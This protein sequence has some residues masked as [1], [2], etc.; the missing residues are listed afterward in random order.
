[1]TATDEFLQRIAA[2]LDNAFNGSRR[3]KPTGFVLLTFPFNGAPGNRVNYIS[4][5]NRADVVA[6]LE[7]IVARFKEE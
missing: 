5:A 2:S 7:E 1:M 6:A 4:N 3:P